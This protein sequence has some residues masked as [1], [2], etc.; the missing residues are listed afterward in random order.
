MMFLTLALSVMAMGSAMANDSAMDKNHKPNKVKIEINHNCCG[1]HGDWHYGGNKH[2]KMHKHVKSHR[3]VYRGPKLNCPICEYKA[4][5]HRPGRP[6]FDGS[7]TAVAL[8]VIE[9][10][11]STVVPMVV[12]TV[13]SNKILDVCFPNARG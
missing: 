5:S 8:R 13:D 2:P 7:I 10:M 3:K 9:A 1:D 12:P 6:H 11:A 4:N